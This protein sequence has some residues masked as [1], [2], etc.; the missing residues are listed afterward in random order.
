M[1]VHLDA[2]T[3][4][5]PGKQPPYPLG[6]RLCVPE[7]LSGHFGEKFLAPALLGCR[8]RRL[9]KVPTELSYLS[10]IGQENSLPE[11]HHGFPPCLQKLRIIPRIMSHLCLPHPFLLTEGVGLS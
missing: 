2:S 8:N 7:G 3:T 11:L 10:N 1:S 6:R 4:L 5:L 9:A